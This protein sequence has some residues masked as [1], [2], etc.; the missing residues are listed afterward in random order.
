LA[1]LE[2]QCND[3]V[4]KQ[5]TAFWSKTAIFSPNFEAKIFEK[6]NIG[7]RSIAIHPSIHTY[8]HTYIHTYI[9]EKSRPFFAHS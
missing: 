1:F 7:P 8:T 4:F 2:Q 5:I 3:Q 6:S 9:G